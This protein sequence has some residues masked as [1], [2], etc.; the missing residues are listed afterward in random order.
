MHLLALRVVIVSGENGDQRGLDGRDVVGGGP[1]VLE[2]VEAD[3]ATFRL[4]T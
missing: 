1:P 4:F 3:A 2:D